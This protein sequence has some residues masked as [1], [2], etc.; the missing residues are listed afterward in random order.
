MRITTVIILL[1]AIP[2][3]KRKHWLRVLTTYSLDSEEQLTTTATAVLCIYSLF[4]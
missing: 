2:N 4:Y 1:K 3:F